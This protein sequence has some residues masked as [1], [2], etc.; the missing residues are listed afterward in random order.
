MTVKLPQQLPF[1]RGE[2]YH[3]SIDVID[4]ETNQ[5]A[6]LTEITVKSQIRKGSVEVATLEVV[7][8]DRQNGLYDLVSVDGENTLAWPTGILDQDIIY[9]KVEGGR[10]IIK[11]TDTFQ[12]LVEREVTRP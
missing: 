4:L 10:T 6:D 11:A 9:S 12:L 7:W 8:T 1:K 3:A 2:T 5:P